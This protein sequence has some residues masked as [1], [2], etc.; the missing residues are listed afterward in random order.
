MDCI[1]YY[2]S[3][4]GRMILA[5]DGEKL[6][7]LWF[8]GQKHFASSLKETPIKKSLPVFEETI[9]WLDIYFNGGIPDFIPPL[10]LLGTPFQKEVWEI[11]LTIPYGKTMTYGEIAKMLADRRGLPRMSAQAVG[12]AISRNPISIIV[13]CHRVLGSNGELTGYAGG[14]DKKAWLLELERTK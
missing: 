9:R 11:L 10:S 5:S 12:G 2:S 1:D 6:T 7:G 8:D 3:P 14:I 4:L 13:P